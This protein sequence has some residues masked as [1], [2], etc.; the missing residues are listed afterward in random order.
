[1]PGQ[2]RVLLVL[3]VLRI[4]HPSSLPTRL[5]LHCGNTC[6]MAAEIPA[7]TA[8]GTHEG[9]TLAS[10]AAA[11]VHPGRPPDGGDLG[12]HRHRRLLR[13][14]AGPARAAQRPVRAPRTVD[15]ADPG[16]RPAGR[17]GTA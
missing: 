10:G 11:A 16:G 14:A 8:T 5:L 9:S 2:P 13:G 4:P 15:R 17:S 6:S 1:M 7:G 3:R 12:A